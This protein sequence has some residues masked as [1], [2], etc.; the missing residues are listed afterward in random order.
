MGPRNFSETNLNIH[1]KKKRCKPKKKKQIKIKHHFF[2]FFTGQIDSIKK[3]KKAQQLI[4]L[5]KQNDNYLFLW[6]L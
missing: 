2:F 1:S 3:T 6:P 4:I 5:V